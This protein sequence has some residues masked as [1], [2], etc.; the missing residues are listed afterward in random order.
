LSET[1]PP[2]SQA[3]ERLLELGLIL[4]TPGPPG[5]SY[6][7]TA[8]SGDL[9]FVSGHLPDSSEEPIHTGKLGRDLTTQQGY[10]AARQATLSLLASVQA[11]IGSLSDVKRFVKLFGMV[12]CADDFIEQSR[13]IDGASDLLRDVFGEAGL[14]ARSAVG[15]MQL[16]RNNCVELE[17]II[18]VGNGG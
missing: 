12:N 8:R 1:I 16:P 5:G 3:D 17:A 13:V 6:A 7:K 14:H 4:P 2:S 18:E 11:A 9:L 10:A 15:M